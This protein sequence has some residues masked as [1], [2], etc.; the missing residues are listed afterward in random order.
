MHVGNY[1][2]MYPAALYVYT[3]EQSICDISAAVFFSG[4][5]TASSGDG[6]ELAAFWGFHQTTARLPN[7]KN[8]HP[9]VELV[10]QCEDL[11]EE[12]VELPRHTV[13]GNPILHSLFFSP[14]PLLSHSFFLTLFCLTFHILS[15]NPGSLALLLDCWNVKYLLCSF[16]GDK[17]FFCGLFLLC[18]YFKRP[19]VS[20]RK[21]LAL[22]FLY[23][24]HLCHVPALSSLF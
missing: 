18:H 19:A 16:S 5:R 8:K 23:D 7:N 2:F 20:K 22:I 6:S 11:N 10:P 3:A 12:H 14:F 15:Q 9:G 1:I 13:R 24:R 17:S 21:T 4:W